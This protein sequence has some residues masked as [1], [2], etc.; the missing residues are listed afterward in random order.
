MIAS[1]VVLLFASAAPADQVRA[2]VQH[3]L[4]GDINAAAA[5]W[6]EE[7]LASS[8]DGS[9]ARRRDHQPSLPLA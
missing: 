4:A 1:F 3:V 6:R 5:C 8:R 2:H 9:P 7:D